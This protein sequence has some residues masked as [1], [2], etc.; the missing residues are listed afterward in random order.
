MAHVRYNLEQRVFIYDF[1]VKKKPHT[2]RAGENFTINFRTQ[3]VHLEIQFP[4]FVYNITSMKR[5]EEKQKNVLKCV[6]HKYRY[7]YIYTPSVHCA[8]LSDL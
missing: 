7:I 1:Y 8:G 4:N 2:N 5:K 3:H 6:E